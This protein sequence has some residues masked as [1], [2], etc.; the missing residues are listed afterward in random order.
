MVVEPHFPKI[1]SAVLTP[2]GLV[3]PARH[4][5]LQWRHPLSPPIRVHFATQLGLAEVAAAGSDPERR[6]K[7]FGAACPHV[8]QQSSKETTRPSRPAA[9]DGLILPVTPPPPGTIRVTHRA[10]YTRTASRGCS[11]CLLISLYLS[12]IRFKAFSKSTFIQMVN[13]FVN[14][15]LIVVF[16]SSFKPCWP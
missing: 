14:I 10:K 5:R 4:P 8:V 7:T 6:R 2:P 3:Q 11:N 9:P 13:I 16:R 12:N 15:W 1:R